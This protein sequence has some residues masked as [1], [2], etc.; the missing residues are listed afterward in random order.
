MSTIKVDTIQDTSGNDQ[1]TVKAWV[2]FNGTGTVAIRAGG[3]VSSITDLATGNYTVNFSSATQDSNYS[4]ALGG[5]LS[6]SSVNWNEFH[7]VI[8]NAGSGS[9]TYSPSTQSVTMTHS[10]ASENNNYNDSSY[11]LLQVTR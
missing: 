11:G 8:R 10:H 9:P 6:P 7:W 4:W 5:G 1:F 3:N 2:N